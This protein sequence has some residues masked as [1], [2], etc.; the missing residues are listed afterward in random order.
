[1]NWA[2]KKKV[3]VISRIHVCPCFSSCRQD[4]T[5]GFFLAQ[6]FP[7]CSSFLLFAGR[8][9]GWLPPGSQGQA[10]S[11]AAFLSVPTATASDSGALS[12]QPLGAP[13]SSRLSTIPLLY[14]A[15]GLLLLPSW[16]AQWEWLRTICCND[17][18]LILLDCEV[19]ENG[20]HAVHDL[21]SKGL[22][23]CV[24]CGKHPRK[25]QL[26]QEGMAE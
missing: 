19:L 17:F 18:C 9:G 25:L 3:W 2:K 6:L 13:F 11:L 23:R 24:A 4:T 15:Y 10:Q 20:F 26:V 16:H 5:W 1:M 12:P 21:Y 14:K 22:A 7:G 8:A